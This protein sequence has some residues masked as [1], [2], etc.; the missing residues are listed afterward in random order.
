MKLNLYHVDAF[1]SEV[2]KGNPAAVCPLAEWLPDDVL[3]HIAAENNLPETAFYLIS[4]N[5]VEIRWFTPTVEV[6][7]CGH[8]T[9]AAAF[10]LYHC[11]HYESDIIE[12]YSPR[13]GNLPVTVQQDKLVLN[14]PTDQFTATAL[15]EELK[16]ATDKIPVAVYKG[17]T[18]YMLVFDNQED[19]ET[20]QPNLSLIAGLAARGIIVTARGNTCDFVSRFFGPASGINEDPVT[21]SA[22]T[23]LTPYWA[24]QLDKTELHAL[25][26]SARGGAVQCRLLGDRVELAGNAVLYMKGEIY[27]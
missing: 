25:Q 5:K 1:T 12:F 27:I 23:T 3:Q 24:T 19:I 2:F 15:T 4:N 7:L 6:D 10:V 22:H 26:L 17:K 9:L 14:F 18:D 20:M 16:S 13:S 21:G 8:A 11:E